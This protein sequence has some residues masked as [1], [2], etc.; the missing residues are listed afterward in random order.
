MRIRPSLLYLVLAGGTVGA[1][2]A[3]MALHAL[4]PGWRWH[5]EPLHSTIEAIGGLAAIAM[6]V[7]LFQRREEPVGRKFESLSIGF[8]GMGLLE[9]FHA[10]APPGNAFVLLR[11]VASLVAGVGFGLVWLLGSEPVTSGRKWLPWFVVTAALAFGIWT[12]T[13]PEQ[14]PVMI[15]NGEFTPTAVAPQSLACLFFLA[16]TLRF[17]LDYRRSGKSEDYLFASLALMF[18]LAELVFMYSVPWDT[19]WWF[20]HLL[21]L[22]ACLIVLGYVGRGYFLMISNLKDS[23]AQTRQAEVTLRRS[24]QQ[25]RQ[26]L[27]DRERMA[28]DLHDGSIQSIFAAGLSLERCRRLITTDPKEVIRQLGTAIADLKLVIRDLRGYIVG[29]EP[30]ISNGRELEAALASLVRSM[31]SPHQLQFMLQVNSLAA[32]RVTPAQAAHLLSVTREAMSNSLRH[33]A[34]RTGRISLQL[35]EGLVR[36]L[37]EDD[38]VG[39][40][41]SSVQELG[42]GL[43][44]ME[45]RARR[46]GGRLEVM[47]EPGHGT[48]VVFDL[49]QEPVHAL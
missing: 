45:A 41:A 49:P 42:H 19:R 32:D 23:L 8:L 36:L 20:W 38:G 22:L 18:G 29:L 15:R 39:F 1:L 46:L 34:A 25:L 37:V 28:Q 44:N 12:L 21:R 24:E 43:K 11:N 26:V 33:S 9:G 40:H 48:R 7:V 31:D 27:D 17:L 14:I 5:H 30:P 13:F 47:S 4:W 6:A 35:H 2:L 3:S 16:A 10:M